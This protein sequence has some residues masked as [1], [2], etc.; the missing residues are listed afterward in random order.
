M[1]VAG[2]CPSRHPCCRSLADPTYPKLCTCQAWPPSI[3]CV[4]EE[5]TQPQ[6]RP[7]QVTCCGR[8]QA[9]TQTPLRGVDPRLGEGPQREHVQVEQGGTPRSFLS[10]RLSWVNKL[11]FLSLKLRSCLGQAGPCP[12]YPQ[13][14]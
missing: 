9:E 12:L 8:Q 5:G 14:H 11:G 4:T 6:R 10:P 1:E 3:S 13:P 2:G 7:G